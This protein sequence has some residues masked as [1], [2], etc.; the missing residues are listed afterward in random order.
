[1]TPQTSGKGC[2]GAR[3]RLCEVESVPDELQGL[4]GTITRSFG[5]PDHAAHNVRLDAGAPSELFWHYQLKEEAPSGRSGNVG[6]RP[7]T[8]VLGRGGLRSLRTLNPNS[9][10]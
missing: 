3:V 2:L 5:H 10:N 8:E 1:M 6:C 4:V 9:E 7:V